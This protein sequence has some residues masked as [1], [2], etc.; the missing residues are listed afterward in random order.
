MVIIMAPI[1]RLTKHSLFGEI[2][3]GND[4][5]VFLFPKETATSI[6]K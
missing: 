4:Y 2:F 3:L 1:R 5:N 6:R